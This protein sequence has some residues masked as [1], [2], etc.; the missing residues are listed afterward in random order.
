MPVRLACIILAH[1]APRQL[2]RL[3]QRLRA[4]GVHFVLH[5][6][7]N[8]SGPE[9]DLLSNE[10]NSP[11]ITWAQRVA[12]QWGDFSLVDATLNCLEALSSLNAEFDFVILL[13][14]QDYP[15]K[16]PAFFSQFLM[17]RRGQCLMY[18]YP[19]PFPTW[20][21]G[22][23][24]RLPTWRIPFRGKPRRLLPPQLAG[25]RH[26][27]LPFGYRPFGGSQWWCLPG[28]AV[29][30]I[31][32]FVRSHPEFTRYYRE[33]LIP[34]E[35]FFHTILGNSHFKIDPG[36]NN[37]TYMKWA[38]GPNPALLTSADLPEMAN[39][40]Y[41]FARKFDMQEDPDLLDRVDI[42]LIGIDPRVDTYY[43]G[44]RAASAG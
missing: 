1:R 27:K 43:R 6:D 30:Y 40:E 24:H 14:G 17:S 5:L 13:S 16:P 3:V 44:R 19:F 15:I 36:P 11:D 42:E 35:M 34:D 26:K 18:V 4:P 41:L 31:Y 33:A 12:C 23:Y 20:V 39:S 7:R 37:I 2:H 28:D 32:E 38:G 25:F 10:L 9:W 29:R 22:G 8:T 21:N